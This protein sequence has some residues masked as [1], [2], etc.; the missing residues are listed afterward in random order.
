MDKNNKI[1][2]LNEE[3]KHYEELILESENI[4]KRK[5]E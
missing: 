2:E 5:E 3:I 1:G 4:K